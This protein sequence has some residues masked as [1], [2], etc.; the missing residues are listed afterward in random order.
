M[1]TTTP[2]PIINKLVQ[3]I[4]T[5][6]IFITILVLFIIENV[7][8]G[9]NRHI[10]QVTNIFIKGLLSILFICFYMSLLFDFSDGIYTNNDNDNPILAGNFIQNFMHGETSSNNPL[11]NK[12]N[13]S[14]ILIILIG[15][16]CSVISLIFLYIILGKTKH[17]NVLN[18]QSPKIQQLMTASFVLLLLGK[19]LLCVYDVAIEYGFEIVTTNS[20]AFQLILFSTSSLCFIVSLILSSVIWAKIDKNIT[21]DGINPYQYDKRSISNDS[22][23][24]YYEKPTMSNPNPDYRYSN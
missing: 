20:L 22:T 12:L 19:L 4:I 17:I 23:Y 11:P 15:L 16:F 6:P 14:S 21:D 13:I 3:P 18:K 24:S 2:T 5:I 8:T 10:V 1:T 7:S 9:I